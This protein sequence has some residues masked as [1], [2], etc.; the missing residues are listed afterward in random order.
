MTKLFR[1]LKVALRHADGY[2]APY[3]ATTAKLSPNKNGKP[4]CQSA[5]G[6]R[7]TAAITVPQV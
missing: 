1:R 7:Q 6:F 4:N 3:R 2:R 5:Q